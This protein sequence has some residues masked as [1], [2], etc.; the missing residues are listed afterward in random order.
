[1][2]FLNN[3][4]LFQTIFDIKKSF[5]RQTNSYLHPLVSRKGLSNL[6]TCV[7]GEWND[8]IIGTIHKEIVPMSNK[9]IVHQFKTEKK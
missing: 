9:Y 8:H 1:M 5:D 6:E 2:L 7:L 4:T 3:L